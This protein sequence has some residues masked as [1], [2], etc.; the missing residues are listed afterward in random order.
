M[1]LAS[2][3]RLGAY[4]I[5]AP[6][7]AGGMGEV[8]RARDTNLGRDV[9]V[10]VLPDSVA[11]DPDRL[12]RFEREAR[13][14]ASLNHPNLAVVHGLEKLSGTTTIRA[15]VMELV[16]GTTLADRIVEGP[17]SV[18]DGLSIARQI[19]EGLEAAHER[20]IVHR[21][22]KP[23]NIMLTGRRQVKILDFGL[24]KQDVVADDETMAT[25]R[26]TADG[27]VVG[28]PHYLA[29][30]VLQ[31]AR[32]DARSD[33]W[34]FGVVCY[35]MF[36]GRVP[37]PGTTTFEIAAAILREPAPPLPAGVPPGVRAILEQ[38]LA[39]R[40]EDRFQ[41]ARELRAAFDAPASTFTELPTARVEKTSAATWPRWGWAAGSLV[42]AALAIGAIMH[43]GSE[44]P[45]RLSNGGVPSTNQDANEAY[46]F[47]L[48]VQT[49]QNDLPRGQKLLER[50][51]ELDPQFAEALRFHGANY[52]I[53]ILNGYTN[54]TSLLYK[55]EEELRR[56]E[57]IDPGM[58]SLPAAFAAVYLVQG[59][60]ELVPWDGL[61]RVLR[62]DPAH[63]N[64]RLWRGM[65]MWLAGDADAAGKEWRLALD[66]SPLFGPARMFY[67]VAL[68]EGG[69]LDGAIRELEKVMERAPNNVSAVSFLTSFYLDA[70][71]PGKARALL[72]TQRSEYSGNYMWRQAWALLLA[73]EGRRDEAMA[74][75]DGETEK[76]A[77]VAFPTTLYMAEFY[78]LLGDNAKAVEWVERAVR[79]G[80]ERT[81]WF[82]QSPRL[83][84]LRNDPRLE[85]IIAPVEA[86]RS[87]R[88]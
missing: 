43:F 67:G 1:G 14:L 22:I 53:L 6:L 36:R 64:S 8:Y 26:L 47:A 76:F 68:R 32:A 51:L 39:K 41:D 35:E 79:N 19:A 72:E 13:T 58:L 73:A 74:A 86:R 55:A 59:R 40:P 87:V 11:G 18:D 30:E 77:T 83:A 49:L 21:D 81:A 80:D 48:N 85:R 84:S 69:D 62:A 66:M 71:E 45:R 17:L 34:A 78:A 25:D 63:L 27:T 3:T 88:Q 56:A 7:G 44:T 54:D 70:G 75:M 33:V 61:E 52:A 65:A 50:A 28:T 24:A 16:D 42:V 31:G 29:P 37:F 82:R 46:E 57:R 20:G 2:G 9:A 15:I 23:R 12:A 38:C 10:K 5:I 4:E 60:K